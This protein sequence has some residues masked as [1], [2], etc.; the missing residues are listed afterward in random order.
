FSKLVSE[1]MLD[2][3]RKCPTDVLVVVPSD[4]R[5]V[6][7]LATAAQLRQRGF[8]T[9]VYH[10]ADKLAKQLRYASRKVIPFVWLPPFDNEGRHEVKDLATGAQVAADPATWQR[11]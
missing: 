8:N 4:E 6:D 2:T 11:P 1:G 7:A 9:E 10:Q 3:T 5:Y